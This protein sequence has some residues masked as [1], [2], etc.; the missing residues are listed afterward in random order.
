[1]NFGSKTSLS[2]QH[3]RVN[4]VLRT[5]CFQH[6]AGTYDGS[7][8]RLY[9]NGQLVGENAVAGTVVLGSHEQVEINSG[10]AP[11][12][13]SIDEARV[14]NRALSADEIAAIYA[15]GNQNRR[16]GAGATQ[17]PVQ[18]VVPASATIGQ[19][20][21]EA[22]ASGG[23]GAGAYS[24]TSLN[25]AVCTVGATTGV[26]SSLAGGT[27]LLMATKAGDKDYLPATSAVGSFEVYPLVS[28]PLNT[29]TN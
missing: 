22:A 3:V 8:M 15:A 20:G 24:H 1:M 26:I 18:L 9:L 11:T 19:L 2:L 13:G 6:V 29:L 17:A 10:S 25:R 4:N 7:A 14:F 28:C 12:Q 5:G 27:C 16:C 21:L 23:S